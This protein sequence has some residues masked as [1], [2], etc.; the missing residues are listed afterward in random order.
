MDICR[1]LDFK[2]CEA[3]W[4]A[5]RTIQRVTENG[6]PGGVCVTL[7]WG[8]GL[9]KSWFDRQESYILV[10]QW[11]GKL[12]LGAEHP[13]VRIVVLMPT[14]EQAKKVHGDL[15]CAELESTWGPLRG[16]VNRTTWRVTFP[17][18]SWIQFVSAE[19]AHLLRGIR[20][21]AVVVDECDD[22]A[23][24]IVNSVVI[25]WFSE[26]HSLRMQIRSGTPRMGRKGLLY[27]SHKLLPA[28]L[29]GRAFAYHATGL[30]A[31]LIVSPEAMED[32]RITTPEAIYKREWLCD[33]DSAEGLVYP[34]FKEG[35]HVRPPPE[36][37][38]WDDV[39]ICGDHGFTDPGVLLTCGVLGH[40]NDA[41]M[42]ILDEVYESLQDPIWWFDKAS[43][44][45]AWF[46]RAYWFLDPSRP[47]MIKG[48]RSRGARIGVT[49]NDRA[50]GIGCVQQMLKIQTRRAADGGLEERARLYVAP[51]C[52]QTIN[53]FGLYRHKRDPRDPEAMTESVVEKTD[54]AM[55]SL[56]YG[57][58]GRFFPDK[59]SRRRD[60][61]AEARQ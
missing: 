3:Q 14:L 11:D 21:D 22:V 56:R 30:D 60:A 46:P 27:F 1:N 4:L 6:G 48:Y 54:H 9:G 41:Q 39:F 15:L 33:Y 31:P 28:K 44:R 29:P 26:P 19:R 2:K 43:E 50:S 42:W 55:D 23:M 45:V 16:K 47:D 8:R 5:H 49:D 34:A 36:G 38:T 25:P 59:A 32:A 57:I 20:C 13:G 35:F 53:E 17:G 37:I 51:N 58:V 40:G 61:S 10:A 52:K 18:G 7:P 12:R 24:S